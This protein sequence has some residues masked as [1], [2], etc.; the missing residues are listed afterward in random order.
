MVYAELPGAQ[1]TFD[2]YRSIRFEA[3]ID[4]IETF[5]ESVQPHAPPAQITRRSDGAATD[6]VV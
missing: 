1:H 4:G 3:V 5:T 6:E 2:L